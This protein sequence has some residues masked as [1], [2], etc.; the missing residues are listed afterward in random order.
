MKY[1][2][3]VIALICLLSQALQ[4][5]A[6][7]KLFT[8]I[9]PDSSGIYF[10]NIVEDNTLLNVIS[11]EYYYNGGGVAVGDINND[12]LQDLFFT[13]NV[14]ECKL[15]LNQGNLKFK[16]ITKESGTNGGPGYHTGAVM[17]DIN[18]DGWLD[19]YVCKSVTSSISE[20]ENVLYINN[21]NGTFTNRAKEFGLNDAGFATQAYFNDMD[22][23]GDLDCYLLNHPYN[24]NNAR[25]IR[26][27]YNKLGQLEAVKEIPNEYET[28]RYYENMKGK[29]VDK[30]K[31]AG[32]ITRAFALSAILEDFN[33]DG[34][35]D[36]YQCNDYLEPDYLFI[37]D[38]KNHFTNKH[39]DF[40][41]HGSY[42][43]MGSDYA[44]INN[45][46]LSDLIT[47]DMLPENI[48]RQK[49]LRRSNNYDEFDMVV[50]YGFGHQ[51][52]K[53]V[54]QLNN[55]NG[56]YS[57]I[58]YL[59]SMAYSDWSW[60]TI[61]HDFDNDGFKDVYIANGYMRDIT[62]MDFVKFSMDS[63]RKELNKAKS[64]ADIVSILSAIPSVKIRDLYFRNYGNLNFKK[65]TKEA[66]I[67]E[68]SWSFAATYADLD[69]DGDAELIVNNCN[70]P[71]FLYRNNTSE[72]GY[73]K[74]LKV[75]FKGPENNLSG[76]GAKVS[77][78]TK[79]GMKQ[80]NYFNPFRG[81]LSNS[82]YEVLFGCAYA[83]S[84]S[85]LVEW[86]DGKT[87]KIDHLA[88]NQTFI[89][90][91]YRASS[92]KLNPVPSKKIFDFK[93]HSKEINLAFTH[94][95]ND[96]ID[97]KLEPLLPYQLSKSG[98]C[99]AVGDIDGDGLEDILIGG[100][101]N[102]SASVYVQNLSGR[103]IPIISACFKE[104]APFE[105]GAMLLADFDGDKDLDLLVS[106]GGND[107]QRDINK[108]PLRI[109]K[110][111]G[112]GNF[113]KFN[114]SNIL[115]IS[116]NHLSVTD[117][118]KDG[119]L[120]FF[121]GGRSVPGHYGLTPNSYIFHII[122][123]K[124]DTM[125][126]NISFRKMG[127]ITTASWCDL[128]KNGF[129]DLV[130]AGHWMDIKVFYNYN[131]ILSS[132]PVKIGTYSSGWWNTLTVD[133][134]D[135]D[136]DLDIIAGN[137]G[138]NSRYTANEQQ[139]MSMF[140]NDF[141]KNGST[142][143]IINV[144]SKDKSYP[145]TIRD[146]LLDQMPFLRKKF[147]R[148]KNYAGTT[149]QDM[150]N[151]AVLNECKIEATNNMK[152][153]IFL[154]TNNTFEFIPFV[155]EAQIAPINGIQIG[156]FDQDGKKDILLGGNNFSTEVETGRDD[157]G[158]GLV[159]KGKGNFVF[160]PTSVNESG[161]FIPGDVKQ[162]MPIQINNKKH[163]LIGNNSGQLQFYSY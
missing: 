102:Q 93:D 20:R 13:A 150:F 40:F 3:S 43:S 92:E 51:Y 66:G 76:I 114:Y 80:T 111:D 72:Y 123:N 115:H 142:D 63:I 117:Y 146:Y 31:E 53:N 110:N 22:K 162:I 70:D 44:D 104:D 60:G 147:L 35:I 128:D 82:Q 21:K 87:E 116:A 62:D 37:N 145:I 12:G 127:M 158:I 136:G 88:T 156:D 52:A 14:Y 75:K 89:A 46:G 94:K 140:V 38:G 33:Q 24:L 100:A 1:H 56:T 160:A 16:D 30:T 149:I 101:K 19:I 77:I 132:S 54:V 98:P 79:D 34:F 42:S 2:S 59:T 74:F 99:I 49:S 119:T 36:I 23:D 137:L 134:I 103:F 86:P 17:V 84:V 126:A 39:K 83:D 64:N 122:G 106:S 105:D 90:D 139:P 78:S 159:L 69:N 65:M 32:L 163:Y 124:I 143:I 28:C 107:Y 57:D 141:D 55:G 152:S 135:N 6:P 50:K 81:Y 121:I 131:G 15:Y 155:N 109:Y 118:D 25:T 112:K 97:F 125:P 133:D 10:N 130:V 71:A 151:E 108:Y 95:E 138:L 61:I 154:N 85:I 48:S 41:K 68:F 8:R 29:F 7:K 161:F 148:Y 11:Y 157:A 96:Y 91:Y 73:G 113:T 58:S 144:F 18:Q 120:D 9:A 47:V 67:E 153:G 45:D 5:Q 26:L 129:E 4:G 27:A